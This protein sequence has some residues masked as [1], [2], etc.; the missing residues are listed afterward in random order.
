MA[1]ESAKLVA[2]LAHGE[3]KYSDHPYTYHLQMV[4]DILAH[5]VYRPEMVAA[6]W[7][8]DV[9]EDTK[10]TYRDLVDAFGVEVANIVEAC[11]GRGVNRKAR[12][13]D[14]K[15]KL[16]E[17]QSAR[18]VKLA[19]RMANLHVCF[20]KTN[21]PQLQMYLKE[22]SDFSQSVEEFIKVEMW[23]DYRSMVSQ[24]KPLA[25]LSD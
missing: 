5:Y 20:S 15:A 19:D 21:H 10:V 1:Y 25:W 18:A 16:A 17:C 22:D 7:L 13:S 24:Q 4:T 23:D 11:T 12:Q 14:I 6:G 9:L 8:H 2:T 3:Q